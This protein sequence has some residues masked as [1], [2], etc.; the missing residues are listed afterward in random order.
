MTD[1]AITEVQAPAAVLQTPVRPATYA[2][3][4][5]V[6]ARLNEAIDDSEF[7][8]ADFKAYEKSRLT[9]QYLASLIDADPHHVMVMQRDGKP[10]GFLISGPEL[11]TLWLYWAYVFPE[12]RRSPLA[13]S[14]MRA[15]IS[16]WD[17][18]RFHKVAN[19]T[20]P[21]NIAAEK[22][23]ERMGFEQI[24][25]LRH[26]I[27]GEDF[28]LHERPLN[29]VEPGYDRGTQGGLKNRLRRML[30]LALAR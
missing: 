5:M 4:A 6:H 27:F 8:G 30:K 2:D 26:H 11:G 25:T 20:R 23:L 10:G 3:I 14:A 15:F 12:Y 22:I 13:V 28:R 18:G 21:G 16:H 29:K 17:N 19:Y 24:A 9:R 1:I 7:Y